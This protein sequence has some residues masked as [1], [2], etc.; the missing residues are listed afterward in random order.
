[1]QSIV[2][3]YTL[4]MALFTPASG[5]LADRFGTRR[6]YLVSITLFVIGS[7]ACASA[8]SLNQLV[9]A[10]VLQGIGGS[11]LLPIGRLAILRAVSGEA[12]V[13]AL[14]MISVAGQVGP[15]L[16]PTLG[17][18]FV[19]SFTWHWIFLINVP[20]GAA[21]LYAVQRFLPNDTLHDA[22]PFDF[23]G[24]GLLSLCMVA[25][26][27]ALDG[28]FETHR[29]AASAVLFLVAAAAA[30]AYVPYARRR[31]NRS[32]ISRSFASRTLA[33]D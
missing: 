17:G 20:I 8:H 6:V 5:W 3:A 23:I 31:R 12:Y 32:F 24:C 9:V 16:G 33:W 14:A 13:S 28:P 18:W 27:L 10:R 11:M 2:V 1:M 30:F 26:S 15:I 4:T 22:P 25:F 29:G 7:L 19:Q 21:G